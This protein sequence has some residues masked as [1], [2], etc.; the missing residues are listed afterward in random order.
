MNGKQITFPIPPG[1]SVVEKLA[2]VRTQATTFCISRSSTCGPHA[3]GVAVLPPGSRPF[4]ERELGECD[5]DQC[6]RDARK[7][8]AGQGYDLLTAER[9]TIGGKDGVL[10]EVLVDSQLLHQMLLAELGDG[11]LLVVTGDND[12]ATLPQDEI[13][14]AF[15]LISSGIRID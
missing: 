2:S 3:F 9:T 14:T 7:R 11:A 13:E 4:P 15:R 12:T 10:I 6:L 1:Y 8:Y 5:L